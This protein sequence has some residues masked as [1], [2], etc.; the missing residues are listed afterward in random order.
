MSK[1]GTTQSLFSRR[2][3]PKVLR[4]SVLNLVCAF[5]LSSSIC[6][7]SCQEW[8]V[9]TNLQAGW[10]CVIEA[11]GLRQLKMYSLEHLEGASLGSNGRLYYSDVYDML[12]MLDLRTGLRSVLS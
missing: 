11:A 10:V 6:A 7:E 4:L 9:V 8:L 5:V 3:V 12:G 1:Q 2:S